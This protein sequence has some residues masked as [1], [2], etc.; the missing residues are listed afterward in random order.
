[1]LRLSPIILDSVTFQ[2]GL[3]HEHRPP[4]IVSVS[5]SQQSKGS[6]FRGGELDLWDSKDEKVGKVITRETS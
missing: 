6:L 3:S 2:V 1:M 5:R 4:L